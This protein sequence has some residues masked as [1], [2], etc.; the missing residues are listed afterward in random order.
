MTATDG[1]GGPAMVS[2]GTGSIDG[3]A[4]A[5]PGPVLYN[6]FELGYT[7]DPYPQFALLREADPV[8]ES[9]AG[10]WILFR[11]DDVQR[12]LRD[13]SLSVEDDRATREGPRAE[14]FEQVLGDGD[15]ERRQRGARA[16]LNVDP[17]D[18][19]RLRRLVSKA[20]TPRMIEG[21]RPLVERLVDEAL[22][23]V[24]P[25]G[26]MDVIA[27]LAFPLPFTVISELLG[28][29]DGDRD[30]I[31]GW[32]HA[33]VKTLDP[34][35]TEAEVREAFEASDAMTDHIAGVLEWKR[36]HPA[37]DLLT[38]LI[39]AEEGGDRLTPDELRDQV[40]LLFIA[41][42]ETTVNLIGNGTLALLR[43]PDQLARWRDDPGLD[44]NAV[45]ELLRYDAPVQFSRRITVA[46]LDVAGRTI[47]AGTFVLAGLASS[48]RDPA[49]W[50]PTADELD[51]A[52]PTA[53][54]HLSF[55]SGT[56]FCLGAALARLEGQVAVGRLIRR[57]ADLAVAD[58]GP[59]WN[60]RINLRGLDHLPVT[61][62]S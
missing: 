31:R 14:L 59:A 51:L 47:P 17:P 37:D 44:A 5:P 49:F 45:D 21:L 3:P 11:Y 28:M 10:P 18:H 19:T 39:R 8:H 43:H 35:I 52:R 24:A 16:M 20:F 1:Q 55:G 12:L 29:P 22:D 48:N 60:G 34:V 30:A 58:P 41:G 38:A 4:P 54:Q 53:A 6:P 62:R 40:V 46:P 9:M 15:P 32:S 23:R 50:G 26:R 33:I 25:A 7:E 2:P 61:F 27:D 13:A 57:F 36:A 42:H 56:H